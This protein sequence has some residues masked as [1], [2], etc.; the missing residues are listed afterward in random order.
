M[1]DRTFTGGRFALDVDGIN[2]GFLKKFSGLSMEAD[3]VAND[4]Y[5]SGLANRV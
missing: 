3:I 4:P 5:F 2:V 1:A